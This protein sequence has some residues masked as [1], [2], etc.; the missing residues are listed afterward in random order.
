MSQAADDILGLDDQLKVTKRTKIPKIDQERLLGKNGVS[1]IAKN[2]H[3]VNRII[4]KNDQKHKSVSKTKRYDVEYQNL[5]SVLQFYQ[6]WCHTMFPRAK[7]YDGVKLI[8]GVVNRAP[9][10]KQ[11]RKKLIEAEINKLRGEMGVIDVPIP[12]MHSAEAAQ[13]GSV[14]S[15]INNV[16]ANDDIEQDEEDDYH[17]EDDFS[18]M[19]GNALFVDP[20]DDLYDQEHNNQEPNNQ[21]HN[22]QE[23]NTTSHI[24]RNHEKEPNIPQQVET[25][26]VSSKTSLPNDNDEE[27]FSDEDQFLSAA[28]INPKP[29]PPIL[30]DVEDD[31]DEELAVMNEL[32]M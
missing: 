21:E 10:L 25:Q 14:P 16:A 6:L 20:D 3:K 13:D 19:T 17:V 1:Y 15:V 29:N 2:Y 4:K 22:N 7:F 5:S 9:M 23:H 18:F 11:Y 8:R 24:Q 26:P 30:E 32:G 28:D 12:D 31:Y 27:M